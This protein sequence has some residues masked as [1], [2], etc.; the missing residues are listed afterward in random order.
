MTKKFPKKAAKIRVLALDVDGVLT[1]GRI[2]LDHRGKETKIF[3][4]QDGFGLVL[5]QKMGFQ[6][7]IISARSAEAVHWRAQD[8]KIDKIYQDAYP[9]INAYE[10]MLKDFNVKDDQVCFVGDDLPDLAVLKRAGFAVAVAN[11]RQEVKKA[12]DYVTKNPGGTG[13]V[14]EVV[15]LILKAQSQWNETLKNFA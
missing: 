15:E 2:I 1:N 11:A 6:T 9:K 5:F 10:E 12:S 4:V 8:L 14:R 7:A 13:A 3:D